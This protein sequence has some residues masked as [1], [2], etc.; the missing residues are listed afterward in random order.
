VSAP[1]VGATAVRFPTIIVGIVL[2]EFSAYVWSNE[3]ITEGKDE[4][5]HR[6]RSEGYAVL[7]VLRQEPA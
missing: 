6:Q 5:G 7:L 4:Q 3:P 2:T 1:S